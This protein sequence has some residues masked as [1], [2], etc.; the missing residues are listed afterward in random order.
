MSGIRSEH[1]HK[2]ENKKWGGIYTPPVGQ[3]AFKY[4]VFLLQ[5]NKN[6]VSSTIYRNI[7]QNKF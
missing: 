4:V 3:G 6:S 5:N 1:G 7:V 2:S